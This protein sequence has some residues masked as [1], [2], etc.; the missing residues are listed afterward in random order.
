MLIIHLTAKTLQNYKK[1]EKRQVFFDKKRIKKK[2]WRIRQSRL[3]GKKEL[4]SK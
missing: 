1:T 2:L 4:N 3:Q